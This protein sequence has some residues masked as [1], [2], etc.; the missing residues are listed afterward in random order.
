MKVL[1][2]LCS[3]NAFALNPCMFCFK[4]CVETQCLKHCVSNTVSNTL[5]EMQFGLLP[6]IQILFLKWNLRES[7]YYERKKKQEM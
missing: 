2:L 7:Y 4:S 1:V 6:H 5:F 3:P